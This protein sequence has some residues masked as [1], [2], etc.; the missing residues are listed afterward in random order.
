MILQIQERAVSHRAYV[1]VLRML[2]L[3]IPRAIGRHQKD[4]I[5]KTI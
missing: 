1:V 5:G 2:R 3:S 4:L